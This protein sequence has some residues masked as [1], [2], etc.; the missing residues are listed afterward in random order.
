MERRNDVM[1]GAMWYGRKGKVLFGSARIGMA[2]KAII[3]N[4]RVMGK[5]NFKIP[6]LYRG[7]TA[8]EAAEEL[9]RIRQKYG[10]LRPEYVVEESRE[11][12]SVLHQ[13]FQWNDAVAAEKYRTSQ[14]RKLIDNITCEMVNENVPIVV[15]AFVNVQVEENG[16]R[17]YTPIKEAMLNDASY[18]DMLEQAKSEMESFIEKY[19]QIGELGDVKRE[20]MK[21]ITGV[22]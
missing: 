2:G 16:T 8:D 22:E 19:R 6:S 17:S 15:R 18:I 1:H 11:E 21:V 7:I 9:D 10:T 3:N 13:C 20:M 12:S 5:Y 4:H 14:A